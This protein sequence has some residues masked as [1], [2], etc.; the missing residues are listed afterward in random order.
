MN[1]AIPLLGV[2][3]A[4][5]LLGVWLLRPP[6]RL[7]ARFATA[8]CGRV[9]VISGDGASISGIEDMA[10]MPDGAT[11]LLS[12]YDRISNKEG[13][14]YTVPTPALLPDSEVTAQALHIIRG[15]PTRMRPHGIALDT[16]GTRLAV[17]NRLHDGS[18]LVELGTLAG[19][20]WT[21]SVSLTH[22]ELC[23]ANDLA[24]TSDG[25][26]LATLDRADCTPS[27][28]D[29]LPMGTG[30][31][32]SLSDGGVTDVLVDLS[33]A[34]GVAGGYV[35]ETRARRIRAM[36]GAQLAL[37]GGPDN[38]TLSYDG[39]LIAAVHPVLLQLALYRIGLAERAATRIVRIVPEE[40]TVE[41]LFDDPAGA[42]FAGAT[43][44]V[45][46]PS[47]LIAGSV[48]DHGLL[49]CLEG[50]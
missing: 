33:F 21:P 26:F 20:R 27:L 4:V 50:Q 32:V 40:S 39:A 12:A 49:V 19:I 14:L 28:R 22:P 10:L 47:R 7:A 1:R 31:L 5:G 34:N 8:D 23:R 48:R 16:S 9:T 24:F 36:D 29:L 2:I 45:A 46:T 6:D 25:R 13:G 38:L 37:P 44:A 35:A 17:I 18:A 30:R 43:S 15:A 11:L 3:L 41:V 42:M